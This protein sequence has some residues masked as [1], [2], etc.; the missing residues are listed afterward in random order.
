MLDN[1]L[2]NTTYWKNKSSANWQEIKFVTWH[3]TLVTPVLG[4][5]AEEV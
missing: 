3:Y 1:F 2:H 4:T 5:E